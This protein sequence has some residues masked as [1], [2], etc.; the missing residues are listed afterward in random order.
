MKLS[1]QNIV[2]WLTVRNYKV[3]W[4]IQYDI[5]NLESVR[6]L[7][8]D[9]FEQDIVYV[10]PEEETGGSVIYTTLVNYSND[11][12]RI[13]GVHPDSIFQEILEMFRYFRDW[14]YRLLQCV[15]QKKG[16]QEIIEIG[17]EVFRSPMIVDGVGGQS[18]GITRNYPKS[19]HPM[20]RQRMENDAESYEYIK[21]NEDGF[22]KI[23]AGYTYP[24]I[25][26]SEGWGAPTMNTH[27]YF[28]GQK[29][30]FIVLYQ[31]QR[32]F[33]PGDVHYLNVF[34]RIV[35]HFLALNPELYCTGSYLE[36]FLWQVVTD[37]KA[38]WNKM[39]LVLKCL[40]WEARDTYRVCVIGASEQS[41]LE[42]ARALREKIKVQNGDL[43]CLACE[44]RVIV[45]INQTRLFNLEEIQ[46]YI[47]KISRQ[48]Y[49][50]GVSNEFHDIRQMK[51]YYTQ[52]AEALSFCDQNGQQFGEAFLMMP[53][54]VKE[55]ISEKAPLTTFCHP[56]M[57]IL[58]GY[59]K[60]N[61]SQL[62]RTLYLYLLSGC[63]QLKTA[64]VM[65]IH[66]NTLNNR[67]NK[68]RELL[69]YSFDDAQKNKSLLYACLIA[70][71]DETDAGFS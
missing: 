58:R 12:I 1:M 55:A 32:K 71:P 9:S 46:R 20:W 14:E 59:D 13:A 44:N 21:K 38:D 16:L 53:E 41:G 51:L 42:N 4:D 7:Y 50:V 25:R 28:R 47:L 2:D 43:C 15:L 68:I 69:E 22:V 33:L 17:D 63:N 6:W 3:H 56:Y 11:I 23:L 27:L 30:G 10:E 34:A 54:K 24:V 26:D 66:R 19:I 62:A 67:L 18:L 29:N 36:H 61:H 8:S 57:M 49:P 5:A 40:K 64:E 48:G 65:Y 31:Y 39:P 70:E 52:G 60:A 37:R 45:L 35:E